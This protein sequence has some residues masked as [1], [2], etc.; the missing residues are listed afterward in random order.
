[1]SAFLCN[2][3]DLQCELVTQVEGST[4]ALTQIWSMNSFDPFLN[5]IE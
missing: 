5:K 4:L 2:Y 3:S 1:M